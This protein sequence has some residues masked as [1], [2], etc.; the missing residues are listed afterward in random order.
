[1]CFSQTVSFVGGGVLIA[2]GAYSARKALEINPQYLPASLMPL[3]AGV[4]QGFEGHVWMGLNRGDSSM[5]SWAALGFIFFSWLAWPILVPLL[6]W[7]LEPDVRKKRIMF[8]FAFAGAALGLTM[9]FP[10]ILYS[11]WLTVSIARHSIAYGDKMLTDSFM[12]REVTYFIYLAIII[13]PTLLSSFH[14]MRMF[15]LTLTAI[16][17]VTYFLLYYAYISFFCF[18][19]AAGTIHLIYIILGDKCCAKYCPAPV[20]TGGHYEK[21]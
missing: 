12:P 11:D 6:A 7:R 19:A 14:H 4:Q 18:L 3:L 15:G 17:L 10:Y 5:I 16:V 20:L 13:T 1:M 8:I 2:G 21:R 9:F